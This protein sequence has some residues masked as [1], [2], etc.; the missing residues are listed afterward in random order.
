MLASPGSMIPATYLLPIKSRTCDGLDE[1]TN[2]LAGLPVAELLIV[3]GSPEDVFREH[4]RRW[5]P[6]AHHVRP[7]NRIAGLNGKV[8]GVLT[9]FGL[10][11]FDKVIIAD[12]DVRHSA[13]SVSRV[14]AL[15]DQAE[16]VLPQNFF[17]PHEWHT[18]LDSARILINR[19]IGFDWPGT[20][21]V[22]RSAVP[23]GYSPDVLFENLELVRTV[24]ARGGRKLA[25]PDLFVARRPPAAA[26][27][28]SQRVRQAYDEF[29]RPLRMGVSLAAL[30]IVCALIAS[31][32][33]PLLGVGAIALMGLAEFGRRKDQ[34]SSHF[35][36]I[37]SVAAPL[38][39]LER[40]VCAWLA[41]GSL[42]KN[43]GVRYGNEIIRSA[44]TPE[45]LLA[46]AS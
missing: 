24:V 42:A 6:F 28:F 25:A 13:A 44:A 5:A 23:G 4:S 10:A 16:I 37:A 26:H 8:R 40:S 20:L 22:R 11:A 7:D 9:G 32:R 18:V 2:Y 46:R 3:D 17:E 34:G 1:L 15:L 14:V 35:P 30:P 39:A 33:A 36:I 41:L 19:A 43:G 45:R 29:A 38:W 21:G 27:F 31:R 12:D